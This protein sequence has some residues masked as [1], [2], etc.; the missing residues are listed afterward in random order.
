M[1]TRLYLGPFFACAL[2]ACA[3][4]SSGS[5]PAATEELPRLVVEPEDPPGVVALPAAC[6][7]VVVGNTADL[8][9]RMELAGERLALRHGK[10][11]DTYGV[12]GL[13]AQVSTIASHEISPAARELTGIELLRMHAKFESARQS[14]ILGREVNP[15]E[16]E[17]LASDKMPSALV[18]WLPIAGDDKGGETAA[19]PIDP[20]DPHAVEP[21]RP[22]GLAYLTAAFERQVLV[23]SVQGMRN[24]PQAALVAKAKSW[25]ATVATSKRPVSS[26]QVAAEIKA[27]RAP[28]QSCPGRA[29][30]V[31]EA[32]P[33]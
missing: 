11:G 32:A 24:E 6:G 19:A 25:M 27:A 30:A 17:I 29:N 7:F 4:N 15:E 9:F 3:T 13:L 2:V 5:K 18:W 14:E 23:L 12:D 26:R 10:T 8:H 16:L 22:T 31:F 21:D 33:Q 20:A 28:G 1:K